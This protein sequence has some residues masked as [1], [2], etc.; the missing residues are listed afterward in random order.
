M[1][2]TTH[3][4]RTSVSLGGADRRAVRGAVWAGHGWLWLTSGGGGLRTTWWW[5]ASRLGGG[6]CLGWSGVGSGPGKPGGKGRSLHSLGP[7]PC[8]LFVPFGPRPGACGGVTS[9]SVPMVG[10]LC[11]CG[12]PV[13]ICLSGSIWQHFFNR[14]ES[15]TNFALQ[16]IAIVTDS[17]TDNTVINDLHMAASGGV[18]VY[19]ILNKRSA[20][21]NFTLCRL[22]HPVSHQANTHL[23]KFW[24]DKT[25]IFIQVYVSVIN[26]STHCICSPRLLSLQLKRY[27]WTFTCQEC[28]ESILPH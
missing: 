19:I 2:V 9:R 28:K 8:L 1:N 4:K 12:W 22:R 17:L 16:V 10:V 21:E 27:L 18:P 24:S 23:Y 6:L 25:N 5:R 13:S 14:I 15:F 3:F 7:L 11:A 20:Q 26:T